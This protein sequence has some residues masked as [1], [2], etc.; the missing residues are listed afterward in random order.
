M[1]DPARFSVESRVVETGVQHDLRLEELLE[2]LVALVA[3]FVATLSH[4]H[5]TVLA[6]WVAHTWVID[7][8]HTTPYIHI[9]SAEPE[10]GKTRTLEVLEL[11]ACR[12]LQVVDPSPATLFRGLQGGTFRTLLVDEVDNYLG[13]EGDREARGAVRA[14]LNSGYRRGAVVPRVLDWHSNRLETFDVFGPKVLTGLREL[15]PALASRSLRFRLQK[16]RPDESIERFRLPHIKA[17]ITPLVEAL[18]AWADDATTEALEHSLPELP[19]ELSDRQQDASESLVAIA[20]LAGD[21]WGKRARD[22]LCAVAA[23]G[24]A[25]I[26]EESRGVALLSDVRDAVPL[27]GSRLATSQ[28]LERLNGLDER[29]WGGWNDGRG[30]TAR[31]L[32]R[33]LKPFGIYSRDIRIGDRAGIKGYRAEDLSD[34][35]ARYLP[36]ADATSA[37][38]AADTHEPAVPDPRPDAR[39]WP[40]KPTLVQ[41]SQSLVAD[42]ADDTV[43]YRYDGSRE[44]A[45]VVT[46]AA[47]EKWR[48]SSG[49][50]P[51]GVC[52]FCGEARDAQLV[53][54][55]LGGTDLSACAECA[56]RWHLK[57]GRRRETGD[58]GSR[59][60]NPTRKEQRD[61]LSKE[62]QHEIDH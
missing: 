45:V 55:G 22:A 38:S 37:T 11:V 42:V 10:S 4:E 34:A 3:R 26:V 23:C 2:A 36:P 60:K 44:G 20:D 17:E 56:G 31:N 43:E 35:F 53:E 33:I 62:D 51:P 25:E 32:A 15:P 41:R 54:I 28:L 14:I 52:C 6:L 19:D 58:N 57:A 47:P 1:K 24:R 12:P 48:P 49:V 27:L 59:G 40:P 5:L 7:G 29:S 21:A 39:V 16:R 46:P 30:M 8:A 50:H 13:G 18:Q 9:S 61:D